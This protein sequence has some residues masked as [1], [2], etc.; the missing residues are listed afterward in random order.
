MVFMCSVHK[1][2][3]CEV[4]L[5]EIRDL[6]VVITSGAWHH[7][8]WYERLAIS[9]YH[10]TTMSRVL[11]SRACACA[12]LHCITTQNAAAWRTLC[13]QDLRFSQWHY[14]RFKSH[15]LWQG[16][17]GRTVP[18]CF[19]KIVVPPSAGSSSPRKRHTESYSLLCV[20][21]PWTFVLA[22]VIT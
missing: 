16:G 14:F 15:T 6:R 2:N 13:V 3:V 11:L 19:E 4:G 7:V 1:G 20:C 5:Y 17:V 21:V 10:I 12:R 8:V 9:E 18:A 22:C